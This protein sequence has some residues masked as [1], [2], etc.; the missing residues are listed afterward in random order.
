MARR[1][2]LVQVTAIIM[3]AAA[4]VACEGSGTGPAQ[5]TAPR[6]SVGSNPDT[7]QLPA[8]AH[9]GGKQS[10]LIG[11]NGGHLHFDDSSAAG[12]EYWLDVPAGAVRSNTTFEMEV[13]PGESY[14]VS[15]KATADGGDVGKNGFGQ[16]VRL[17]ISYAAAKH[18]VTPT[19]I[20]VAW[21]PDDG[22]S[23]VPVKTQVNPG[24][25]TLTGYLQHFSHYTTIYW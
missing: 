19:R 15:L 20:S 8:P 17:T 5:S 3:A 11:K 13:L 14:V 2:T 9:K 10:G 12:V 1:F 21:L 4:L 24:Q 22:G 25:K 7:P 16:P 18:P 23:P 6:L